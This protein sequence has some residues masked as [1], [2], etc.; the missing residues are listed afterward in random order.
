MA[1][2]KS[3]DRDPEGEASRLRRRFRSVSRRI[4]WRY[5]LRKGLWWGAIGAAATLGAGIALVWL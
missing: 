2:F 4:E 5:R 3:P 1:S